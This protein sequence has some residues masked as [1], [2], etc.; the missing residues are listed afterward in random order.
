MPT[1]HSVLVVVVVVVVVAV[2]VI[3]YSFISSCHLLIY[4][5]SYICTIRASV[6]YS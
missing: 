1:C 5:C 4:S 3:I 6:V 2:V